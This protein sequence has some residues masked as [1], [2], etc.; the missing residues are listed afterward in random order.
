M[1]GIFSMQFADWI[2]RL[3][4]RRR[5]CLLWLRRPAEMRRA[6]AAERAR[7]TRTGRPFAL[8]RLTPLGGR[9]TSSQLATLAQA[10][11]CRLRSYDIAGALDPETFVVLLPETDRHGGM[12]VA[13]DVQCR[14]GAEADQFHWQVAQYPASDEGRRGGKGGI[15]QEQEAVAESNGE[16]Q[17]AN[18]VE[19]MLARSLPAWKRAMDIA[20]SSLG[21][22]VTAPVIGLAAAAIKITSPG[23][24]LFRQR[25]SGIGGKPFLMHKLRTMTVHAEQM[26]QALRH[27]NEQDGPAFKIENDPRVTRVGRILRTTCIDELPQLW[28]VLRGEMSIVGPRPLPCRESDACQGW[29]RARLDIT[30]GLTCIWQVRGRSK[31]SFDEWMRMDLEYARNLSLWTDLSL[32]LGT[33]MLVVRSVHKLNPLRTASPA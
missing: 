16:A 1:T 24:V 23:P 9:L 11:K 28:N 6:L 2:R 27:L 21:L 4:P 14:L 7:T 25:R 29:R 20:L 19:I 17:P 26:Q 12:N 8:I 18:P 22:L 13:V 33:V 5:R 30:P 3:A 10:L 31:V 32:I 15:G